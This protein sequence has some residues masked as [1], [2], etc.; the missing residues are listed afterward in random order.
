MRPGERRDAWA[1]FLTLF[2]LV[3][4]HAVLETARD[5]LFLAKV[6]ATQLPWVF[7]SV[8]ALSFAL[9][10]LQAR[11]GRGLTG[12]PAL[13]AWTLG[14]AAVT[15]AFHQLFDALGRAGVYA[16]YVWSGVL[17]TLLLVHFW[18]LV[19]NIFTVTQAKRLY[20][21]IGAGSVVGAIAGSGAASVLSR[22]VAP[23][24]LLV[25]AACGFAL[26]ALAPALFRTASQATVDTRAATASFA[27]NVR[28]VRESPYA[29]RVVLSLFVST[30]CLTAA[31]FLFKSVVAAL[32]PPAQLA[33]FLG[34]V[35]FALNLA[36]LLCQITL[37]G[38]LL[39][40]F[41]LGT[42]LAI[43]PALLALGG[44]GVALS[45]GLVAVLAVKSADGALRH[46]LHRTAT[47]LLFLPFSDDAR[48]RV[49]GFM[50]VV[51]QRGGQVLASMAILGLV[52]LGATS[53]TLAVALVVLA[54]AWVTTAIA[55]REP[56][57][58][59]FRARLKRGRITQ[60]DDFPELDVASLETL[61]AALDSSTDREVSAALQVLE[62][63]NKVHLVPAVIL[64][65]PADEVVERALAI[66]TR[67][68]RKNVAPV[69]DRLLAHP[70]PRVRAAT[71]AA[72]SVL[73]PDPQ[74]LL[75]RR[76]VEES[77]EVRATI[78]VN[79]IASGDVRG[80]EA[81]ERL[82]AIL[83]HGTPQANLALAEAIA[84][85]GAAGFS[86]VLVALSVAGDAG[87]RR[88]A[89]DAMGG[90]MDEALVPALIARLSD[91][92]TRPDAERVLVA[93]GDG[94]LRALRLALEDDA[95]G[96]ALRWRIPHAVSGFEPVAASTALLTR[97][98]S[99]GSGSVRYQII[100]ALERLVRRNPSLSLDRDI[101][102]SVIEQTVSRSF[103]LL[104][105]RITLVRGAEENASRETAGHLL[106]K[107]L[108]G[109][110]E[111]NTTER[112]FRLLGLAH[113]TED[114]A[115]IH[116]GLEIGKDARATSMELIDG[117]LEEPLRA[118]VLGLVDD[119]PDA[120]R[121]ARAG[122]YHRALDLDYEGLLASMLGGASEATAEITAFH[123]A[124][125]GLAVPPAAS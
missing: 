62:R 50:D 68:G 100:R 93:H 12:R 118:A 81:K 106:L 123:L 13:V 97:L 103:R 7:L 49:K 88:A 78:D 79:L 99:E 101:V 27:D 75:A 55:L 8:A 38:W 76:D 36:S 31:D 44:V 85:R 26:S 1:A 14:A 86:D 125:L 73:L 16:L 11:F 63:E 117:L 19:G 60:L 89:V 42:S 5:A 98:A 46:S 23:P 6:P 72:R 83:Q 29:R 35:Y 95:Q 91:E 113:P 84:R 96:A 22:V 53:R 34:S 108:L 107:R 124:E 87:V 102:D 40:R 104:D 33:G 110:K 15:F 120:Q 9:V 111:K 67:A 64:H 43:L 119:V 82:D 58:Q 114:F 18:T 71:I 32:V 94:A 52:A 20:G 70:S 116:R 121:L 21:F 115:E 30:M 51:G 59:L 90:V 109:D 2:G 77:A 105:S 92:S 4:S 54:A 39:R 41:S 56:Y 61:M 37:V 80:A 10:R 17:T 66:F 3:G 48:Q 57:I 112:L 74:L 45:G 69:I 24:R 25:V 122:E 47:E 28:Y 65:H